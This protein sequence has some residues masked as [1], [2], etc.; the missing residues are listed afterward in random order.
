MLFE[1]NT[2]VNTLLGLEELTDEEKKGLE[3]IKEKFERWER[4]KS[5]GTQ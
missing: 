1:L 2:K 4:M 5:E 3:E